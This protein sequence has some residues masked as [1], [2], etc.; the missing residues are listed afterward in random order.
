MSEGLTPGLGGYDYLQA[1]IRAKIQYFGQ[2]IA[3][4][5]LYRRLAFHAAHPL[6]KLLPPF[7]LFSIIRHTRS[8]LLLVR[9]A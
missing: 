1:T 7:S 5:A 6:L 9:R 2:S 4:I 8:L 3:K